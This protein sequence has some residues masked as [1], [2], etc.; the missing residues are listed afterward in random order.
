MQKTS[1]DRGGGGIEC[2][3]IFASAMG[4]RPLFFFGNNIGWCRSNIRNLYWFQTWTIIIGAANS[5]WL[6]DP[7][8]IVRLLI[9]I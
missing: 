2:R 6:H 8:A 3:R 7:T 4:R 1:V 9:L 5:L